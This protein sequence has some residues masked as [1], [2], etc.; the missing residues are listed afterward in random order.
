MNI[1]AA[2]NNKYDNESLRKFKS[3]D[4]CECPRQHTNVSKLFY[5]RLLGIFYN[6]VLETFLISQNVH[7]KNVKWNVF[8]FFPIE[9]RLRNDYKN[10]DFTNEEKCSENVINKILSF[11]ER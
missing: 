3:L 6:R 4:R 11:E 2:A 8:F 9:I 1:D 5:K 7:S 10:V